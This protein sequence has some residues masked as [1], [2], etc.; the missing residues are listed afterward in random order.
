MDMAYVRT[1]IVP[2]AGT[3]GRGFAR[4]TRACISECRRVEGGKWLG[5]DH[6]TRLNL[7]AF[8]FRVPRYYQQT[9]TTMVGRY[10]TTLD[11]DTT[12]THHLPPPEDDSAQDVSMSFAIPP[13]A[14]ASNLLDQNCDDF[15]SGPGLVTLSTPVIPRH[16]TNA[17]R[18]LTG[19]IQTPAVVSRTILGQT[20]PTHSTTELEPSDDRAELQ[21]M[22]TPLHPGSSRPG[23]TLSESG[24]DA[25]ICDGLKSN[26]APS[27]ASVL[28]TKATGTQPG[29]Q[30]MSTSAPSRHSTNTQNTQIPRRPPIPVPRKKNKGTAQSHGAASIESNQETS[31]PRGGDVPCRETTSVSCAKLCRPSWDMRIS[32]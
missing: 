22:H 5:C 21:E 2:E 1:D 27:M 9:S 4:N 24:P 26:T 30:S 18:K 10:D 19:S 7:D 6:V 14:D 13:Q 3:R 12:I 28:T 17:V 23:D 11:A 29:I 8:P 32:G 16:L 20:V 15:F 25:K 31:K